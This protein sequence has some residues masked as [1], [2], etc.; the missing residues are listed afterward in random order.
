MVASGEIQ[1]SSGAR[2][3][4]WQLRVRQIPGTVTVIKLVE[5]LTNPNTYHSQQKGGVVGVKSRD[6]L[7]KSRD[8]CIHP[9]AQLRHNISTCCAHDHVQQR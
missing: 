2:K 5:I 7:V 3:H 9:H 8:L 1:A 6:S 4:P